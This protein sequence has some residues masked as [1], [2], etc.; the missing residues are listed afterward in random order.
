MMYY[1][2]LAL[3]MLVLGCP[4][5]WAQSYRVQD[6][7][8]AQ[9]A[10]LDRNKTV[11]II[12]GGIL[13]EHG[14]AFPAG[15]DTFMNEW[16]AKSLADTIVA[17]PGWT[18]LL[19][20]TVLSGTSGANTLGARHVFPGT[21]TLRPETERAMFMDLASEIGELGFR[22]VFVIHNHGSPLHNLMLDQAGDYFR[23]TYRGTMVNLPGLILPPVGPDTRA[24]SVLN[25]EGSFEVH[26]GMS[27]TSRIMFLKPELVASS[28]AALKPNTANSPAEAV[29]IASD[30][31]WLGYIGSPRLASA[32]FGEREMHRRAQEYNRA[33]LA[34]LDG[35]DPASFPRLSVVLSKIPEV[36]KVEQGTRAW[37]RVLEAKQNAWLNK[38]H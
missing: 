26:A 25:E 23:D 4:A 20:P 15:T 31:N 14:P 1:L 29:R 28:R 22:W 37:Y 5:A 35:T 8:S 2:R 9:I 7:N 3:L 12:P 33:A 10:A 27:E 19:F 21:F 38:G 30:P 24:A 32:A 34:I 11:I 16:W 6:L 17:R 36:D 18:V 13:E